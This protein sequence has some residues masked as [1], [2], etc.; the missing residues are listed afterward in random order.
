MTC[1]WFIRRAGV[2]VV[3]ALGFASFGWPALPAAA[4]GVG[5]TMLVSERTGR[6][7]AVTWLGFLVNGEDA[8][9][10]VT[11]SAS[12]TPNREEADEC[13]FASRHSGFI[14]VLWGDGRV[15]AVADS[16][17]LHTY[18]QNAVRDLRAQPETY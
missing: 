4:I 6:K 16:I 13:D 14:N 15:E 8:A 7:L 2:A 18:Q 10:R 12:Q 17:D 11:G 3:L 1:S 5:Q 9:G